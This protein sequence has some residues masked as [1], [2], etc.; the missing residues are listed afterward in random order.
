MAFSDHFMRE[1]GKGS[2]LKIIISDLKKY[3]N[4]NYNIQLMWQNNREKWYYDYQNI[5]TKKRQKN[6]YIYFIDGIVIQVW[7][8]PYKLVF[9][10]FEVLD[11]SVFFTW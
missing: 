8:L 5:I 9:R 7:V 1:G 6:K 2:K 11:Y 3:V 10:Y 4:L